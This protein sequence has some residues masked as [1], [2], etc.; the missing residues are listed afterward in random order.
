MNTSP[1]RILLIDDD[2][3]EYVLHR[4]LLAGLPGSPYRLDWI[5]D[6][7]SGLAAVKAGDHDAYLIDYHLGARTGTDLLREVRKDGVERAM[8]I[9]TGQ[10]DERADRSAMASGASDYLV[11]G[12]VNAATLERSIRYAIERG[13]ILAK[14]RFQAEILRN[15]HDAVFYVNREGVVRDWNEG[16]ARIF[17]IPREEAVGRNLSEICPHPN[18]HPFSRRILP[19]IRRSGKAEETIH[20]RLDSGREVFVRAKATPMN[21]GGEEGYVFCASDITAEKRLEAEI[22]RIAESEQ[23][24]IG[25]DIHDDLCS[26]LSGIGCLTK[27]LEQRLRAQHA[28]EAEMMA[29][30]TGMVAQAGTKA[31]EI[32]RGLVPS[33]LENQGLA[34]ALRELATSRRES[35]GVNCVASIPEDARLERLPE[36]I[37]IQL[38]RIAQEA[39]TNAIRHSDAEVIELSLRA[40]ENRVELRVRDD[41][42]GMVKEGGSDGLGLLTMRRRAELISGELTIA[43][44]PG[45]GTDVRCIIP[46]D[47]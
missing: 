11:K 41:G 30:I 44:S 1:I 18:G 47:P 19:E 29:G 7:D 36:T 23:R 5:P 43:A 22:V 37:S 28:E 14:L 40:E 10:D 46:L 13:R 12:E 38:Y 20:C 42:R 33:V 32:A 16:A 26:Q 15:V 27:V 2:E 17:G 39:V 34:G 4:D 25:Q 3:D 6:F 24:R 45:G 8:I 35:F 31:R 9:L 21:Q